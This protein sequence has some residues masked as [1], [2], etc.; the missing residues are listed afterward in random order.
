MD[1]PDDLGRL[2][3]GD[4]SRISDLADRF[5]K[6]LQ[7]AEASGKEVDLNGLLPRPGDPLR[8][9]ALNELIKID[10]EFRCRRRQ[11]FAL[12]EHYLKA[13]PELGSL[14]T[15][16]PH[17]VHWEYHLNRRYGANIPLIEYQ[18]RYPSQYDAVKKLVDSADQETRGPEEAQ[19]ASSRPSSGS[20]LI[21]RSG[22]AI[23]SGLHPLPQLGSNQEAG[24]TVSG[25][26]TLQRRIG[27]GAFGEVWRATAPGGVEVAVKIIFRPLD[28]EEAKSELHA[29]ELIKTL[30]HPF[31]LQTHAFWPEQDRLLIVMELAD[32]S[33][34]D[35]LK[36]YKKQ[37]L[38]GIPVKELLGYFSQAAQALDYLHGRR[39]LHRDIKPDNILRCEGYAKVAD[40][41]LAR[42][43]ST[44]RSAKVTGS[45]T[46]AYMAPEMWAS[47]PNQFSDQYCFATTYAELRLARPLFQGQDII[48]LMRAHLQDK[49]DLS[50]LPPAEQEV[51]L[52][53]LAKDPQKRFGSCGEFADALIGAVEVGN[54]R[55]GAGKAAAA[56]PRSAP[57][58][59]P[60]TDD[61]QD[62]QGTIRPGA[63]PAPVM[64]PPEEPLSPPSD[65]D[66]QDVATLH[67]AGRQALEQESEQ[68]ASPARRPN[69][70]DTAEVDR[71]R[72]STHTVAPVPTLKVKP[73]GGKKGLIAA[74]VAAVLLT[75]VGVGG[76]LIVSGSFHTQVADFVKNEKFDEALNRIDN[77]SSLEATLGSPT[78]E[79]AKVQKQWQDFVL[80]Q[81]DSEKWPLVQQSANAYLKRFPEDERVTGY[82]DHALRQ[83]IPPL[84]VPREFANAA[85]QL[86]GIGAKSQEKDKLLGTLHDKWLAQAKDA[87]TKGLAFVQTNNFEQGRGQLRT[88]RDT[89]AAMLNAEAFKNDV[90]ARTVRRDAGNEF[91]KIEVND[92]AK[93]GEFEDALTRLK[94]AP[95]LPPDERS[96]LGQ[97]VLKLLLQQ[98]Q[99]ELANGKYAACQKSLRLALD[100]FRNLN[101]PLPAE[102]QQ[103]LDTWLVLSW[104]KDAGRD[105]SKDEDIHSRIVALLGQKLPRQ[106]MVDVTSAFVDLAEKA[107]PEWQEVPVL[108]SAL[109][110]LEPPVP[111]PLS[112]ALES[113]RNVIAS[114]STQDLLARERDLVKHEQFQECLELIDKNLAAGA[115]QQLPLVL[116]M[117]KKDP[118]PYRGPIVQLLNKMLPK[119]SDESKKVAASYSACLAAWSASEEGRLAEAADQVVVAYKNSPEILPP[120]WNLR[121]AGVLQQA[122]TQVPFTAQ[123]LAKPFKDGDADKVFRWLDSAQMLRAS[124]KEELPLPERAKLAL[125]ANFKSANPTPRLASDLGNELVRKAS[126]AALGEVALPVLLVRAKAADSAEAK[127]AAFSQLFTR[128]KKAERKA[129]E[130]KDWL[131]LVLK[132]A[133]A[134]ADSF[135]NPEQKPRDLKAALATCFGAYARFV[136]DHLFDEEWFPDARKTAF[137]YY[138][139]AV[140]LEDTKPE[141]WIG[142]TYACTYQN[143]VNW[144]EVDKNVA[145]ALRLGGPTNLAAHTLS[146]YVHLIESRAET[147]RAKLVAK[148]H[149]ADQALSESLALAQTNKGQEED[150]PT[151]LLYA[152][153]VKL[154]LGNYVV[155]KREE[156]LNTSAKLAEK[157]SALDYTYRELVQEAWGN[158]LEDIG[159]LVENKA[160]DKSAAFKDAV[161]KFGNA[162]KMRPFE[163]RFYVDRGR[164]L[165]RWVYYVPR[166]DP[167]L[168]DKA[169]TDL[170]GAVR[171]SAASRVAAEAF[172]WKGMVEEQRKQRPPARAALAQAILLGS[173]NNGLDW[174]TKAVNS[175]RAWIAA[176][177]GLAIALAEEVAPALEK[178]PKTSPRLLVDVYRLLGDAAVQQVATTKDEKQTKAMQAVRSSIDALLKSGAKGAPADLTAAQ[179]ACSRL[180]TFLYSNLVRGEAKLARPEALKDLS[181]AVEWTTKNADKASALTLASKINTDGASDQEEA[182]AQRQRYRQDAIKSAE[183]AIS[184]EG[185]NHPSRAAMRTL[186]L[187]NLYIA[188][189][190]PNIN[191]QQKLDY[192]RRAVQVADQLGEMV[193]QPGLMSDQDKMGYR[194]LR[195]LV[196]QAKSQ[197]EAGGP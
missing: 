58:P 125:A 123:N 21:P 178:E 106:T 185:A 126:T 175:A 35:L 18:K 36:Q 10:M 105:P 141:Y 15:L 129:V 101:V 65:T 12:D 102:A 193:D 69:W 143:P 154:E 67:N 1:R 46:P 112:K 26:Y 61:W 91:V 60:I 42:L 109:A 116:E 24:A 147:D 70:K 107:Y 117:A 44:R 43:M 77:A 4:Y 92:L 164:A 84:L 130:A 100:G 33:L 79:R 166:A 5:E 27:S 75:A 151:L 194:D 190:D 183:Q 118:A 87:L 51:L 55:K 72:I 78:S 124:Q 121:A 156:N 103:E 142:Y 74:A 71:P 11:P 82:L 28:N 173:R 54:V 14:D 191:Q 189:T 45:G 38:S 110:K 172:Y 188:S 195:R 68:A 89:A 99:T 134:V 139:K 152:S 59:K 133:I 50:G 148:L 159:M 111:A 32:G 119:L 186:L 34:R 17:L 192:L 153:M 96:N 95:E 158:A 155:E 179:E 90:D 52:R 127:V 62:F 113:W 97:S 131:T 64:S 150:L 122:A 108:E 2:P 94:T 13:Y 170:D 162:I 57:K 93:K 16:P 138:G 167:K 7:E 177:P 76:W 169:K 80:R 180:Y 47:Q 8:G 25:G 19:A 81:R 128:T 144:A 29:M 83:T 196:L 120:E 136:S 132:P 6:L 85:A 104:A 182:E 56:P 135:A 3:S 23:G 114:K 165:Y 98:A 22:G 181:Q 187:L 40:F 160:V 197:V 39:L 48:Q 86:Q 161:D 41:G 145:V 88:A 146:G 73:G 137:V 184:F 115:N 63:F 53:A 168:L 174:S 20:G 140:K 149:Q 66:A 163:A 171:L 30:R 176:D 31:L 37:G 157:A 9:A 49:P